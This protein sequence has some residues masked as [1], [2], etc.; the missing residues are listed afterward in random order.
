MSRIALPPP[1]GILA[2]IVAFVTRRMLG[3]VPGSMRI[4]FHNRKTFR[5]LVGMEHA[6]RSA[7]A[8]DADLKALVYLRVAMRVGCP[9]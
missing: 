8:L 9:A 3:R 2:R 1:R 6:L 4:Q 7:N 5:G